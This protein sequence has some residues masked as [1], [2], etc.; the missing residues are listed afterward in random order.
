LSRVSKISPIKKKPLKMESTLEPDLSLSLKIQ[1]AENLNH[2]ERHGF[3][4]VTLL[5]EDMLR[6]VEKG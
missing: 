5:M 3:K 2:P 1:L 6:A 4:Q